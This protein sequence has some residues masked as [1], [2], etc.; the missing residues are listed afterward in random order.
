MST[1]LKQCGIYAITNTI[2][3]KHYIGS[4]INVQQRF[5]CHRSKLRR[6]KH[7]NIHL[8]RAWNK[9]EE[10]VFKFEIV[11]IV[12]H[13]AMLTVIEQVWINK[14]IASGNAYNFNPIAAKPPA[15]KGKPKSKETRKRMS[16]A[17]HRDRGQEYL[18]LMSE[19][20]GKDWIVIEPNGQ[21]H[22]V[23]SL[24]RF[25]DNNKLNRNCMAMVFKGK[26][27]QTSGGWRCLSA[28]SENLAKT[29][30]GTAKLEPCVPS[31]YYGDYRLTSPDRQ[32][33]LVKQRELNQFCEERGMRS[34]SMRRVAEGTR[35]HY[36]GWRCERVN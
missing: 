8:Q 9:F 25:C 11:E 36:K 28:T 12:E 35:N 3:G 21:C 33:F 20:N 34:R 18:D 2:D 5:H 26:L 17:W 27:K 14:A 4:S 30:N 6:N 31:R 16:E 1:K 29:N 15:D 32:I 10:D 13:P 24:T 19:I 23:K 22:R 7:E